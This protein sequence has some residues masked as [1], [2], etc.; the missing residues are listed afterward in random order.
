MVE[1]CG[2]GRGDALST[3]CSRPGHWRANS[4]TADFFECPY[5]TACNGGFFI[6]PDAYYDEK[7]N[8]F[9]SGENSTLVHRVRE[10]NMNSTN[11]SDIQCSPGSTG[12][13]CAVCKKGFVRSFKG[14]CDSC[15]TFSEETGTAVVLVVFVILMFAVFVT[16]IIPISLFKE[17][18]NAMANGLMILKESNGVSYRYATMN[19]IPLEAPYCC[20]DCY[21]VGR[22]EGFDSMQKLLKHKNM[23]AF[24]PVLMG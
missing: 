23:E 18:T 10:D 4:T 11:M 15:P 17:E 24:F 2:S 1:V 6:T 12:V 14:S 16:T 9:D 7:S 5:K 3:M 19:G 8:T 13:L 20:D 21:D 22:I